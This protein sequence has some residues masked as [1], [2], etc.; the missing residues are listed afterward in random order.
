MLPNSPVVV[1][2]VKTHD[3]WLEFY[4]VQST[5]LC[6]GKVCLHSCSPTSKKCA[7]IQHT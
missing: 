6:V 7:L 2:K 5:S 3:H 4:T 1:E